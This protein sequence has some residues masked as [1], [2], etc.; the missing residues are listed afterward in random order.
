MLLQVSSKKVE[1]LEQEVNELE[2]QIGVLRGVRQLSFC[3]FGEQLHTACCFLVQ[4]S[5]IRAKLIADAQARLASLRPQL[6]CEFITVGSEPV[7]QK[8]AVLVLTPLCVV[9]HSPQGPSNGVRLT[10]VLP[11][12]PA[13]LAGLREWDVVESVN[14]VATRTKEAFR[15][16]CLRLL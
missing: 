8:C 16:V 1:E 6:G 12:K 10:N 15:Q 11:G 3:P 2:R 14:G 13:K 5:P 9:C 7:L 4:D